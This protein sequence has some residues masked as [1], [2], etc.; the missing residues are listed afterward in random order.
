MT[1]AL[2]NG[3]SSRPRILQFRLGTLLLA[4]AWVGL[5]CLA[6][7]APTTLMAHLA[8]GMA[9]LMTL[10]AVLVAIYRSGQVRAAALG[11]AIFCGGFGYPTGQAHISLELAI[12]RGATDAFSILADAIHGASKFQ[13]DLIVYDGSGYRGPYRHQDFIAICNC[14]V[15]TLLGVLGGFIA[16][17]LYATRKESTA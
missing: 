15:A 6:V 8:L 14:A 17:A 12:G 10:T 2:A 5:V 4:T 9:A 16:Q 7:R 11:F 3:V 13:D 1:V